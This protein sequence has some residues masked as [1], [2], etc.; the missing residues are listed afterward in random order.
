VRSC[1]GV[2]V[3]TDEAGD[4]AANLR[5]L[6]AG[7]RSVSQACRRIGINRQQF[8]RYLGGTATPSPHNLRRICAHF[9]VGEDEIRLP[10]RLFVARGRRALGLRAGDA[11]L[12]A[13]PGDAR[14]L[15]AWTGFYHAHYRSP[16]QPERI[17]R[18]LVSIQERDGQFL[19][20]TIERTP[21]A[22]TGQ[23]SRARYVG[24]ASMHEGTLFLV[25]RGRLSRGGISETI[26]APLHR[27]TRGWLSGL[28]MGFSWR[29][30][31]PYSSPCLWKRLGPGLPARE[32]LAACGSFPPVRR[33]F[34]AVVL[35]ALVG[36]GGG[37]P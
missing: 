10:H 21:H 14:A 30:R 29:M 20:R 11:L 24:L 25:E 9:G 36:R 33:Q 5:H 17:I 28:L 12:D 19:S 2:G 16:S 18:A 8:A 15:R 34:E 37:A 32:A 1:A 7:E 35:D 3:V 26:L 4:L 13:F 23:I 27:G 22:E 6:C 31:Q